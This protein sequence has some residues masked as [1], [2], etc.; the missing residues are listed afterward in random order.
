MILADITLPDDLAWTDELR[1]QR[2]A[3]T[4]LRTRAGGLIIGERRLT[5]GR[6]ITLSSDESRWI[7]RA[8]AAYLLTLAERPGEIHLL[9]MRGQTYQVMFDHSSGSAVDLV[10]M[11][12]Y[13]DPQPDDPVIG[14]IKLITV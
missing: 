4:R 11:I 7:T 2:I 14:T 6:T 8:D 5:G 1:S 3:Q 13:E 10:P 12:D 9:T